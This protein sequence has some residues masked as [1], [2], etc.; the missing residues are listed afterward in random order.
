MWEET[1]SKVASGVADLFGV[2]G[3]RM[4]AALIAGERTPEVLAHRAVR[5]W[6]RPRPPREVAL[7][8]QFPAHHAGLIPLSL[9]LIDRRDR[10][11]APLDQQ[12]GVLM[13]P[14]TP[15][16]AQRIRIPGGEAPA[17][18][19]ILAELGTARRRCGADTRLAAGAGGC[20]GKN[21]SAGTQRRSRTRQGHRSLRR[22]W[23]PCAWAA[24][25]TP[26]YLGRTCRRLAA[27]LGGKK[28]AVAIAYTLLG[29]VSHLLAEGT[30]YDAERY[31]RLQPRQEER[32]RQRAV[33][34]LAPRGYAVRLAKGA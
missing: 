25:K 14:C 18:R 20:P 10:Q 32:Q 5:R 2:R 6:R 1:N 11:I 8:G 27:R 30:W 12:I 17:A 3:R 9:A 22:V 34:A 16:M 4:L 23:V 24:R 26:L 33:K 7:A 13:P 28:A 29:I 19:A 31:D 21:A 15:Q